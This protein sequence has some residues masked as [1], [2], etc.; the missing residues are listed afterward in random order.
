MK[1]VRSWPVMFAAL[2][3][4]PS[5]SIAQSFQPFNNSIPANA[6]PPFLLT[7][8][9]VLIQNSFTTGWVKLTPDEYGSY[10]NGTWSTVAPLP[11]GYAPYAY[12]SAVLADGRL[13][14]IGGEYNYQGYSDTLQAAVYDPKSDTWTPIAPPLGW[15][16]VGDAPSVVLPT[17]QFLLG[18]AFSSQLGLLDPATLTWTAASNSGK[19]TSNNEEGFTLLPDGTVLDVN[20]SSTGATQRYLP[21]SGKWISAGSTPEPL[22]SGGE[23]GPAVLRPNGTVFAM[24]ASGANAVYTP[25]ST[26]TGTGTW[27]VAPN[28]A[29]GDAPACLLPDGNVFVEAGDGFYEFDGTHLTRVIAS[30]QSPYAGRLLPLPNGQVLLTNGGAQLYIPSGTP[31]PAWAPKITSFPATIGPGATYAISGTQFNGL[32]QAVGF[33]DDYQAATNYPL[34]RITNQVTGHVIYAR[35]HDH[36]TMGVA[37]GTATVST[38]F[39][40]PANIEL[41]SSSLVVVANGIPSAPVPVSVGTLKSSATAL[42]SSPNSSTGGKAVTFTAT[43]TGMGGTPTGTVTFLDGVMR[44]GTGTLNG[45]GVATFSTSTLIA[46]AHSITATYGGDGN[47]TSSTSTAVAQTVTGTAS[48]TALTSS[49]NPSTPNTQITLTVKVTG[50]GGTP[51]GNVAFFDGASWLASATL[52]SGS[53]SFSISAL[54]S[55]PHPISVQYSGDTLFTSST[56]NTVAQF[57][58]GSNPTTV[59]V[60]SSLN[61]SLKGQSVTF[62][63]TVAGAAG[64]MPTGTVSFVTSISAGSSTGAVI[65]GT[66]ALNAS[67]QASMSTNALPVGYY[68][69]DAWYNGDMNYA[70]NGSMTPVTQEVANSLNPSATVLTASPNPA[71]IGQAVT[72]TASVTGTGG[73][74]T[75]YAVLRDGGSFLADTALNAKG[76]LTYTTSTLAAGSHSITAQYGGDLNFLAGTSPAVVVTITQPSAAKPS[77]SPAGGTYTSVQSVKIT[78]TTPGASI[79]YTTDG[80]TPSSSSAKYTAAVKVASSET[81][82]AIATA[83]GDNNSAVATAIYSITLPT[84]ATP[85]FSP[86]GG[87]YN[88]VQTV[89]MTDATTGAA[90]YYTTDG[91]TPTTSST[92]YSAAVKVTS[93]ETLNAMATATGYNNSAV[94]TAAYMIALPTAATPT[95]SPAAGNYTSVQTVTIKDAT[96]GATIYYTTD[97]ST[98]T[99]SSAKYS[100]A[101][102]VGGSETLKAVA[103]ASGYASSAVASAAYTIT[104]PVAATP[105]FSPAAGSYTSAQSVTIKDSTAGATI[106]YT[107]DGSAPTTSSTKY[108]AAINVKTSETLNAI[109]AAKGDAN[110]SVATAAYAIGPA[111]GQGPVPVISPVAGNYASAVTVTIAVSDPRATIYYSIGNQNLNQIYAGPFQVTTNVTVWA[112]SKFSGNTCGMEAASGYTI[113][114]ASSS[115]ISTVAGNGTYGFTGDGGA[116]TNAELNSPSGAFMDA[117]GNLYIADN[118]NN[119]IRKVNGSGVISTYAGGGSGCTQQ[120]DSAGDGCP[121]ISASLSSPYGFAQDSAGSIYVADYYTN[122]VRKISSNGIITNVAGNGSAAYS[123]DGG[124]ATSAAL[125]LPT[126]VA[127]DSA[128]NLYIADGANS[129]VRKVDTNGNISTFAGTGGSGNSG[130]GGPATQAQLNG[131]AT[132]TFDSLGNLYIVDTIAQV[133][134]MVNPSG[135]ISTV[136]GNGKQGFSGDGSAATSAELQFPWGVAVDGAGNLYIADG[137]NGRIRMVN[138]SGTISTVVGGGAGCSAET[139]NRGDNCAPTNARL[140]SPQGIFLDRAGNLLI[141]DNGNQRVRKVASFSTPAVKAARISASGVTGD[142][143][144]Q[145]SLPLSRSDH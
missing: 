63:A 48:T 32:S 16:A 78:S 25:P 27:A 41:G 72:F 58:T 134:R 77:F 93:N 21:S 43:V 31:N 121:A 104:L 8:G 3:L 22:Q 4:W 6:G 30:S 29:V 129:V 64:A 112:C 130:D 131:P 26:L 7:D 14:V 62:T 109:A 36:S 133:V 132:L 139:N 120:T 98:P 110:S 137:G 20:V 117:S 97:G 68:G 61:P 126:G 141:A 59:V 33:G 135:T 142:S 144:D 73:T 15:N 51:T 11:A 123:G 46:G 54:P 45:S 76:V 49:L 13:V 83:I 89:T 50:S 47:F 103:N 55:G 23:M 87:K 35:T 99:T 111:S 40:V 119:R 95:F 101:I 44:I 88:A 113:G 82:S 24:G 42:G 17:G 71:V 91:T 102:A 138:K 108:T 66:V 116:A 105:T 18:M 84:V 124:P 106:Y 56:S 9:T 75:G 114:P 122:V 143:G 39:D 65:L 118:S 38:N 5:L 96:S 136:A 128:G 52:V 74:P 80:S 90:I 127:I 140:S 70:A 12:A 28:L 34:V 125:D 67:G 69:I 60:A 37:T 115:I 85:A 10:L 92:K 145:G 86:A 53:A 19:A 81:L 1:F 100:A 107:T 57:V 79:Y 2:L 94:A